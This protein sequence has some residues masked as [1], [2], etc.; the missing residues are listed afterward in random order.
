[1]LKKNFWLILCFGVL[2]IILA[3]VLLLTSV[4]SFNSGITILAVFLIITVLVVFPLV[5]VKMYGKANALKNRDAALVEEQKEISRHELL[6]AKDGFKPSKALHFDKIHFA[7]DATSK[8]INITVEN[9]SRTFAFD[10]LVSCEML[11]DGEVVKSSSTGNSVAGAML[12]GVA[13]AVVGS[14]MSRSTNICSKMQVYISVNDIIN[15]QLIITLISGAG[16]IKNGI[17]YTK[18]FNFAKEVCST[19]AVIQK[20]SA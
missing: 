7:V 12:F 13:G 5:L 18:A 10:D 17:M 9:N 6:L 16:A 2:L 4:R 11:E 3:F 8:L 20:Q 19:L 14:T 15:P 1:M